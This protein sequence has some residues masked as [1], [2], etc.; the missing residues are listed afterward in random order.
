MGLFTQEP[1]TDYSVP[2]ELRMM[3][4]ASKSQRKFTDTYLDPAIKDNIGYESPRMKMKSITANVDLTDGKAVQKAWLALQAMDPAEATGWLESIKPVLSQQLSSIKIK[5]ANL[6]SDILANKGSV[7]AEWTGRAMPQYISNE[8]KKLY[9]IYGL[10]DTPGVPTMALFRQSLKDLNV[11]KAERNRIYQGLAKLVSAEEK[12][13]KTANQVRD[14]DGQAVSTPDKGNA[15][16][17]SDETTNPESITSNVLGSQNTPGITQ[18]DSEASA[19]DQ[20]IAGAADKQGLELQS[21]LTAAAD[22]I[23]SKASKKFEFNMTKT[24]RT[25]ENK[26]DALRDWLGNGRVITSK[27]FQYFKTN[28]KEIKNFEK[29]PLLWF[30]TKIRPSDKTDYSQYKIIGN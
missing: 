22:S 9:E 11:E 29:N 25:N 12:L 30:F 16:A 6:K 27:S 10:E 8:T 18:D 4:D 2:I 28:P 3:E 5:D 14:F 24:E 26:I 20:L 23:D 7:N 17:F 13:W 1:K 15:N 19:I 21:R